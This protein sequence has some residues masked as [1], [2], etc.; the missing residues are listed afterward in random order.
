MIEN[1]E[2]VEDEGLEYVGFW[3]RAMATLI[4]TIL[5]VIITLPLQLLVFGTDYFDVEKMQNVTSSVELGLN[6]LISWVLPLVLVLAYWSKKQATP[7]KMVYKATIVDAKTGAPMTFNQSILRYFG[8]F[9]SVFP[10]GLGILWVAFDLKK[11]GWH[12]KLA[13]TVV[14]RPVVNVQSSEQN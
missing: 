3:I 2:V 1:T 6:V 5:M 14:I 9:I 12:D 8:Y 4:D 7:G 10:F 13:G 11:Q